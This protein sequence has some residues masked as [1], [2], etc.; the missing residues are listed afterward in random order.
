MAKSFYYPVNELASATLTDGTFNADDPFSSDDVLTNEERATD[1]SIGAAI[2]SW[3]DTN[4]SLRFNLGSAVA[5]DFI[6]LYFSSLS[7]VTANLTLYSNSSSD[8]SSSLP[9]RRK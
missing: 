8:F 7:S 1:Q 4:D 2:T 3:S 5:I 6:A 9:H